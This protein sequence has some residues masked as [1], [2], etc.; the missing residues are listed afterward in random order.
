MI[1]KCNF[2]NLFFAGRK[3]KYFCI[4]IWDPIEEEHVLRITSCLSGANLDIRN[5]T[6]ESKLLIIDDLTKG[7]EAKSGRILLEYILNIADTLD[8]TL[9]LFDQA[10]LP[11]EEGKLRL[12]LVSMF[13]EG[14]LSW[15]SKFGFRPESEE[16]ILFFNSTEEKLSTITCREVLLNIIKH[17]KTDTFSHLHICYKESITKLL[18]ILIANINHNLTLC[19]ESNFD[20]RSFSCDNLQDEDY[21]FDFIYPILGIGSDIY[22]IDLLIRLPTK[23]K[24]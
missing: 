22:E 10:Y 15:Y 3:M 8:L 5:H 14:R 19:F 13:K 16:H 21:F 1:Q 20:F 18:P 6:Q 2:K 11:T 12:K 4:F 23:N 24:E 17:Y 9:G 7:T